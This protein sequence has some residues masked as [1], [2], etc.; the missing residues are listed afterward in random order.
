YWYL[1]LTYDEGGR[2]AEA[3][4]PA[5]KA[6]AL[7]GAQS[8]RAQVALVLVHLGKTDEAERIIE[9]IKSNVNYRDAAFPIAVTYGA[10]KRKE[11]TFKWL[12][13]AYEAG[14]TG[15]AMM[16][17]VPD[18]YWLR[19]DPRFQDLVKRVGLEQLWDPSARERV[20]QRH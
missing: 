13:L 19:S 4:A 6:Y 16:S 9:E 20:Y 15:L 18:L 2:Y 17:R 7:S 5:Q 8:H 3:L 14:K 10:L 12:E 11:E 1:S